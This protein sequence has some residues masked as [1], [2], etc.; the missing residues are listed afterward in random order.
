MGMRMAEFLHLVTPHLEHL[1]GLAHNIGGTTQD[2][3]NALAGGP[4]GGGW[5]GADGH[6]KRRV[7]LLHGLREHPQVVHIGILTME[8]QRVLGPRL[9]DHLHSLA[10]AG[11]ALVHINAKPIKLLTLVATSY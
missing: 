2:R 5:T 4:L 6:V 1:W 7:R 10:E 11:A 8:R 3:L 9:S